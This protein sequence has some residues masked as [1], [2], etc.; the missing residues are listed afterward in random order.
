MSYPHAKR[1]HLVILLTILAQACDGGSHD[2]LAPLPTPPPE[3][4]WQNFSIPLTGPGEGL[5]TIQDVT[6]WQDSP[7]GKH[8]FL[9][10]EGDG[11]A[12]EDGTP[13]V[14]FGTNLVFRA[15]FPPCDTPDGTCDA[16][17][18]DTCSLSAQM[19]ER[20]ARYGI[21]TVRLHHLDRIVAG[22]GIFDVAGLQASP[23]TSVALDEGQL[24]RLGCLVHELKQRGIYLNVNLNTMRRYLA[25]DGVVEHDLIQRWGAKHVFWED[26]I[27]EL[28]R[29]YH[30][31]LLR[32]WVNP[33]TG[34]ALADDP[35]VAF[36]EL[37][38][39]N[40]LMSGWAHGKTTCEG[41]FDQAAAE[42]N[43]I[44]P[45]YRDTLDA[46]WSTWLS[47]RYS[48]HL[49]LVAA[50]DDGTGSPGDPSESTLS[51]VRRRSALDLVQNGYS[52]TRYHDTLSF[53]AEIEV[54]FWQAMQA[55]LRGAEIGVRV[56]ISASNN[57][58]R[59]VHQREIARHSDLAD[60]HFYWDHPVGGA[61]G[62][63][64]NLAALRQVG[65][66]QREH[67]PIEEQMAPWAIAGMPVVLSETNHS[68]PNEYR[69]E[70]ATTALYGAFQGWNGIYNFNWEAIRTLDDAVW[71]DNYPTMN[72]QTRSDPVQLALFPLMR[73][74]FAEGWVSAGQDPVELS[75]TEDEVLDCFR[76]N[77]EVDWMVSGGFDTRL[78]WVRPIRRSFEEGSVPSEPRQASDYAAAFGLTPLASPY[79]S[80][81]DELL[82]D[83]DLDGTPEDPRAR[84]VVRSA[85][86]QGALG[87]FGGDTED[88][89]PLMTMRIAERFATVLLASRDGEPLAR[90]GLMLLTTV[91]RGENTGQ[92]WNAE[93]TNLT[94]VGFAPTRLERVTG[95]V[96]LRGIEG[97]ATLQVFDT[98][99]QGRRL[100]RIV[101]ISQSDDELSF[102]LGG[103]VWY[104]IGQP[105]A[106]ATIR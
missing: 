17:A 18:G 73:L 99:E 3:P 87:D 59:L 85:R 5:P 71:S 70:T 43:C 63:L 103:S 48:D 65:K 14:V 92:E 8:G 79:V 106:L 53:H 33:Y 41:A 20:M 22:V 29:L 69:A 81:T 67:I 52:I 57:N 6:D 98:D 21:N 31:Q 38:N 64:H 27:A 50:W 90:S 30:R 47:E 44:P 37:L 25:G 97:L 10:V 102:H 32:E 104:A 34:L 83:A 88:R 9:R 105:E 74:A 13:F 51:Q 55:D 26:R 54:A 23:P 42:A 101:P 80:S 72:F 60:L 91:A 46:H 77:E 78:A 86:L 35:A 75:Y 12:F 24:G 84:L 58:Y 62:A 1:L 11:F 96:T 28:A 76:V 7:A 36:V 82:L 4:G 2:P 16:D 66:A 100:A 61:G 95:T 40:S 49:A 94:E 45:H 93:R 39:E 19:A 89:A 15:N 56:P 68:W